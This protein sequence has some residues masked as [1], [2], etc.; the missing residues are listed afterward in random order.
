MCM[1]IQVLLMIMGVIFLNVTMIILITLY[2]RRCVSQY[3][4]MYDLFVSKQYLSIHLFLANIILY[5]YIC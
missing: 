1:D 3:L 5:N 2:L 4:V